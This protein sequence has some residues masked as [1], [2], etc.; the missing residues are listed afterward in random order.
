MRRIRMKYKKFKNEEIR[1]LRDENN[2]NE[3]KN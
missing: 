2:M 3:V 1:L